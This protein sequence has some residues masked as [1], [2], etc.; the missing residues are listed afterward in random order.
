MLDQIMQYSP[1]EQ[2]LQLL[3]VCFGV[4]FVLFFALGFFN[5]VTIFSDYI[6]LSWGGAIIMAPFLMLGTLGLMQPDPL[7]QNYDP[8]WSTF[9]TSAVTVIF[10][11]IMSAGLLITLRNSVAANGIILGLLIWIFKIVCSV[12][13]VLVLARMLSALFEEKRTLGSVFLVVV[14]FGIFTFVLKG[15]VNGD[16]VAARKRA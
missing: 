14:V 2:D 7:P 11:L 3:L 5:K 16:R 1:N 10:G 8:Y 4:F 6:D 9:Q 13:F 15:L 12:L